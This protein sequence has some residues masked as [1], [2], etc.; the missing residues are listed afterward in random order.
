M[1]AGAVL[2][3]SSSN[4]RA[5]PALL[6]QPQHPDWAAPRP[7]PPPAALLGPLI[8]AADA[9]G[10]LVQYR[11]QARAYYCFVFPGSAGCLL[12]ATVRAG[13]RQWAAAVVC[14]WPRSLRPSTPPPLQGF[15]PNRRQQRMAGLAAIEYAQALQQLVRACLLPAG[16][17]VGRVCGAAQHGGASTLACVRACLPAPCV[18]SMR[19][20][21]PP[22]L[23]CAGGRP[24]RGQGNDRAQ[25]GG[26]RV[27][28]REG[29]AQWQVCTRAVAGGRLAGSG[30]VPPQRPARR[31]A[32]A[33]V[34]PLLRRAPWM[35]RSHAFGWRDAMEVIVRWRQLA[36]PND[37]VGGPTAGWLWAACKGAGWGRRRKAGC[38]RGDPCTCTRPADPGLALPPHTLSSFDE[39]FGAEASMP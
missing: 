7:A 23:P 28:A 25:C 36:E 9:V 6:L 32:H 29:A 30:G 27:G 3:C 10:R 19:A 8:E 13:C 1:P 38:A 12:A 21:R 24:A 14:S 39:R 2:G 4:A 26:V 20:P 35:R 33:A 22:T 18:L 37:Q 5:P 34:A 31:A 17:C 16:P 15:L 11:H